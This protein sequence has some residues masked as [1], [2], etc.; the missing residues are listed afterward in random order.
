MIH[1]VI[2]REGRFV[3]FLFQIRQDIRMVYLRE[4]S[5]FANEIR[6]RKEELEWYNNKILYF[7]NASVY[8]ITSKLSMVPNFRFHP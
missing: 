7:L 6:L 5:D 4:L 3:D 8:I 2:K 1:Q